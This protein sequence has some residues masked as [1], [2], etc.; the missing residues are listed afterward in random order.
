MAVWEF[1]RNLDQHAASLVREYGAWTYGIFFAILFAETGFVVTPFLP[2]DTLL[3]TA[4]FLA[5]P[6]GPAGAK[7]NLNI[8]LVLTLLTAAPL[9]GDNVNFFLGRWLGPKLF[10][11]P[12]SRFFKK[13]NLDRTHEFYEK[14]GATA[15]IIARWIPIVRTFSPFVAGMGS[16]PYPRFLLF[17]IIGAFVWVWLLV[18]AGYFLGHYEFVHDNLEWVM[19]GMIVVT[20]GP[21]VIEVLR[22]S[23]KGRKSRK[24]PA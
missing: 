5:S 7:H 10:H 11:K 8:W 19:L 3:F 4:G 20:G 2:G 16:M 15:V 9:A 21:V 13:E 24:E 1:I 12:N 22:K 6:L 14:Y 17:S 23:Y 18:G